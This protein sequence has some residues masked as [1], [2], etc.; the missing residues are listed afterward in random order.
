MSKNLYSN[1]IAS[2]YRFLESHKDDKELNHFIVEM[3]KKS[4]LPHSMRLNDCH[5]FLKEHY[6]EVTDAIILGLAYYLEN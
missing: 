4:N 3:C 2:A 1:E 5:T 6:P